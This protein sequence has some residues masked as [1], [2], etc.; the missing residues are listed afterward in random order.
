MVRQL[1]GKL[2][3]DF[4]G[5]SVALLQLLLK[6]WSIQFPDGCHC[7]ERHR[8]IF[9]DLSAVFD[10]EPWCLSGLADQGGFQGF[11]GLVALVLSGWLVLEVSAGS[12]P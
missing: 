5:V 1:P 12:S 3:E 2:L 11:C 8:S 4:W 10:T 6:P 7:W 9:L